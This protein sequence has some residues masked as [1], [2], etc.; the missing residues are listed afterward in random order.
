MRVISQGEAVILGTW[1]FNPASGWIEKNPLWWEIVDDE[2]CRLVPLDD[3]EIT[4]L[5]N[6]EF[7][8]VTPELLQNFN[9]STEPIEGTLNGVGLISAG[10]VVAARTGRSYIKLRINSLHERALGVSWVAYYP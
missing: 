3:V 8:E 10:S 1:Q 7:G 2:V 6:R 5:G 9:Y 4:H